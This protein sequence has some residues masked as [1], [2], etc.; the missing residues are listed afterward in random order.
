MAEPRGLRADEKVE[1]IVA[2]LLQVGVVLSI[3]VTLLGA[4]QY[5]WHEGHHV[6][7]YRVF[8]GEPF[9]LSH[10]SAIVT[11]ALAGHREALIQLGALI[12]IATPVARV[13]FSLVAFAVQRDLTYVVVT[14][15]VLAIL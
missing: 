1:R 12:L 8:R 3:A 7:D 11:A 6:T 15:L 9:D 13:L 4:V 2:I 14:T 10:A 5:L